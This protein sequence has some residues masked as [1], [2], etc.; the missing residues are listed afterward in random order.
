MEVIFISFICAISY[1]I[2][3]AKLF[4]L[5]FIIRTQVFWDLVFTFG[6]PA[7]FMGTYSGMA[8]AFIA[9]VLFSIMTFFL[10]ILMP[11]PKF[12]AFP[13]GKRKN[14]KSNGC[15]PHPPRPWYTTMYYTQSSIQGFKR[16]RKVGDERNPLQK[17]QGLPHMVAPAFIWTTQ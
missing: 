4:S 17:Q 9:G 1:L 11:Q 15:D 10:S 7:L 6:L 3:L 8:T 2:I 13:Y 14:T 12:R 16:Q 5:S